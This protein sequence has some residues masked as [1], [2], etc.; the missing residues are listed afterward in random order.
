MRASS[1]NSWVPKNATIKSASL[2][3]SYFYHNT[4]TGGEIAVGAY[5]ILKGWSPYGVTWQNTS[6]YSNHGVSTTYLSTNLFAGNVGAY[7]SSP[8]WRSFNVTSK[9]IDWCEGQNNYGIALKYITGSNTSVIVNGY[10]T[11]STYRP[12]F[13][14]FYE[15]PPIEDGLYMLKSYYNGLYMDVYNRDVDAGTRVIQFGKTGNA[16]QLFKITHLGVYGNLN[17][18]SVRSMTN[19]GLGVYSNY[20]LS[21]G[22]VSI[23]DMFLSEDF[24]MIGR[25]QTWAI[26]KH[27]S[28]YTLKNGL[29]SS[30][31][32]LS[33]P[34]NS[35]AGESLITTST[36]TSRSDWLFEKYTGGVIEGMKITSAKTDMICGQP[37][38]YKAIMYSSR[39]GCNGPVY[40]S[41][42]N[43]SGGA[44]DYATINGVDG[45]LNPLLPGTVRISYSFSGSSETLYTDVKISQ[46][47]P[48][49]VYYFQNRINDRFMQIDEDVEPSTESAAMKLDVFSSA[50]DQRWR[51][52][53]VSGGYY[54]I[55]SVASNLA[56]TAPDNLGGD[57]T[58][59]T[60]GGRTTQLWKIT[61]V[62][63]G[64]Y[65]LSPKSNASGYI[66]SQGLYGKNVKLLGKSTSSAVEWHLLKT[67]EYALVTLPLRIY[68]DETA[69]SD[70]GNN[71][72][73]LLSTFIDVVYFFQTEFGIYF[74]IEDD[75]A[76]LSDLLTL[77]EECRVGLDSPCTSICGNFSIYECSEKHHKSASRL[78]N[79]LCDEDVYVCRVVGYTLCREVNGMHDIKFDGM[80]KMGGKDTIIKTYRNTIDRI[81]QVIIHELLHNFGINHCTANC[82]MNG[83]AET[84]H[85]CLEHAQEIWD[86]IRRNQI[87]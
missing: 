3:V 26:S 34:A 17:Y 37:Y 9:V 51:I 8:A 25:E 31:S 28:C 50:Y 60:Y 58:Q 53:H 23:E 38:Q 61:D 49:G 82:A 56:L 39:I 43:T 30:S 46:L 67:N 44:T 52:T 41:V 59:Q 64:V 13:S 14:V 48:D 40:Y 5:E 33:V 1:I 2:N 75:S 70:F 16:N 7:E 32:Y 81:K 21:N 79:E 54:K 6:S 71:P 12:Y 18:Y 68:Y 69:L 72:D 74:E 83:E 11:T 84:T 10:G 77:P 78:L 29:V 47:L 20:T 15:E 24:D 86:L 85:L 36:L 35:T 62:N 65:T 27:G 73:F 76:E 66:T 42:T 55:V 80:A 22:S 4:V 63:E 57:V 19:S 45:R 87:S